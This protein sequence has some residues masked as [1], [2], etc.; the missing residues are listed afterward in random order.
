MNEIFGVP[1]NSIMTVLLVMLAICLAVVLFIAI[2]RPVMFKIGVRNIPRRPAETVLV[3]VGL[4]LSTLIIA[5][6]LGTGDTIDY[7][8]TAL[9]YETLGAADQ[10]VVFSNTGDGVGSIGSSLNDRI[11]LSTTDEINALFEGTGLVDGVTPILIET[12]PVFLFADGPPAEDANFLEMAQNG[13][14]TQSEPNAFLTGIDPTQLDG[15]G[16]IMSVDGEVID[17]ATLP[18]GH[19][20]INEEMA[21]KLGAAIGDAIGFTFENQPFVLIVNNIGVDSPLTGKY[22][23]NQPGMVTHLDRLQ[24][25]TGHEGEITTVAVSNT[26][27][28]RTGMALTDEVTGMMRTAFDGRPLGVDPI[29]QDAIEFSNLL[30]SVFTSFFLSV[31]PLFDR[32]RDPAD[33][34]DLFHAGGGTSSRDGYGAGGRCTARATDPVVYLRGN[35]LC[36]VSG[37]DR[38]GAGGGGGLAYR[39]SDEPG[40][41]RFFRDHAECYSEK[42]GR[43]LLPWSRHHLYRGGCFQLADQPIEHCRRSP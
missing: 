25:L 19:A 29:K 3:I 35:G 38:S 30:S 43:R 12:V 22:D 39:Q 27:D 18:D 28:E 5:A 13:G 9:T 41:W 1:M 10:L 7:S 11:P 26:G 17:L 36:P 32:R 40:L 15:F 8:A 20:V 37:S 4:M 33:H 24:A 42:H 14:I 31:R 21:N 34:P 6:A 23:A 16:D 2:R